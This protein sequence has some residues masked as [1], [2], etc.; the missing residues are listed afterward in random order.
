MPRG[1]PSLLFASLLRL[2][3]GTELRSRSSRPCS[4]SPKGH[5]WGWGLPALLGGSGSRSS[6]SRARAADVGRSQAWPA[7]EGEGKSS[8][9]LKGMES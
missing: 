4:L 6:G 2:S 3:A 1:P 9:F 8:V 7:R 5:G